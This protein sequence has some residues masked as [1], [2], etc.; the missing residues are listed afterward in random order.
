MCA[1]H[2]Y[3]RG[4]KFAQ[5]STK[6]LFLHS[7][8]FEDVTAVASE[9]PLTDE[10]DAHAS[11]RSLCGT[12]IGAAAKCRQHPHL[13]QPSPPHTLPPPLC[14]LLT[15]PPPFC[16]HSLGWWLMWPVWH[17][18]PFWAHSKRPQI[19]IYNFN[20][21]FFSTPVISNWIFNCLLDE[22]CY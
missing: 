21:C 7:F 10:T 20:N 13:P 15:T 12:F 22:N 17:F 14:H 3:A 18:T 5:P 8:G 11:Q 9:D 1:V 19:T 4:Q 6:H 2:R 16:C